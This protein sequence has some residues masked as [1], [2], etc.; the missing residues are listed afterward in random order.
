MSAEDRL[1]HHLEYVTTV[2]TARSLINAYAHELAEQIRALDPVEAALAGQHAWHIAAD[3]IDPYTNQEDD[4]MSD[5]PNTDK[6]ERE[7]N[8]YLASQKQ[9]RQDSQSKKGK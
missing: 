1:M 9:N 4:T 2:P 8:D 6:A 7:L 5:K 3:L